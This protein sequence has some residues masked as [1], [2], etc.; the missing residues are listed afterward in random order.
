M[1][2][3]QEDDDLDLERELAELE[4]NQARNSMDYAGMAERADY[5]R[6]EIKKQQIDPLV[7][8]ALQLAQ[9]T[10]H[11]LGANE[12]MANRLLNLTKRIDVRD[13][14]IERTAD[15]D[16]WKE[17]ALAAEATIQRSKKRRSR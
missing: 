7:K 11:A 14:E 1:A 17:R 13:K 4:R 5:L 3:Y 8:K 2:L 16:A 6:T 12:A 9:D 10:G 15:R